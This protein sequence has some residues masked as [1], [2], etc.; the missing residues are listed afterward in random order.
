MDKSRS[1]YVSRLI[2]GAALLLLAALLWFS[3]KDSNYAPDI[4]LSLLDGRQIA[5]SQLQ[6]KPVLVTF[7]ATTCGVCREEIPHLTQLYEDFSAQGFAM[8][9]IAMAY[10]PPSQVLSFAQREGLPYAVALDVEGKAARAFGDVA[11][12]PTSFLIAADGYIL[13]HQVGALNIHDLRAQISTL[14]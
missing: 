4:G 3:P 2:P 7:W 13:H 11:V 6:G 12:T 10:D 5:L 14:L 8:I 1:P 9:A